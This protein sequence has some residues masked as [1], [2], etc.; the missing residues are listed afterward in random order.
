MK[1]QV[2]SIYRIGSS[3]LE[4]GKRTDFFWYFS[5]WSYRNFCSVVPSVASSPETGCRWLPRD[6][7]A[8]S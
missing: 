4:H 5:Q 6:I 7:S 2:R 8:V 1:G 3:V